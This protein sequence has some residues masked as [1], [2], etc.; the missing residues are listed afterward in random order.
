MDAPA[1]RGYTVEEYLDL[2]SVAEFRS[3]YHDG[4]II[5]M[6]GGSPDHNQITGNFYAS[7]NFAFRGQP[8]RVFV[9]DLRLWIPA[10]RLFTYPDVM[11]VGE[12]LELLAGRR[13]TVTNPLVVAEVL[14]DST[15]KYD[16]GDKFKMYRS[17]PSLRE[18]L[19]LSQNR[20]QLERFVKNE[21]GQWTLEDYEGED[22]G[23]EL[24]AVSF[25]MTLKKLY[26]RVDF[27]TSD[28][29]SRLRRKEGR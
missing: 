8:Y 7:L 10:Y 9:A 23:F 3:E 2:E 15:E 20:I 25:S 27:D 5:S 22:V 19:L 26:A 4:E 24:M 29:T 6:P 17:V 21:H 1:K 12:P 11:V 16:R 14:S 28:D 18:Y 13:D